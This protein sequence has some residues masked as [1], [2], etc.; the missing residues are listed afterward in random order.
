MFSDL[1]FNPA[2]G[3]PVAESA[4]ETLTQTGDARGLALAGRLLGLSLFRQGARGSVAALE[5]AVGHAHDADDPGVY[6]LVV[7][8]LGGILCD[9]PTPVADALR[10]FDDLRRTSGDDRIVEAMI[11]RFEAVLLAMAGQF[12]ESRDHLRRSSPILDDVDLVTATRVYR[13]LD[14]RAKELIGDL[15]GAEQDLKRRWNDFRDVGDGSLDGRAIDAVGLLAHLY[16]DQGRW[17]EAADVLSYGRDVQPRGFF[18]KEAVVLLAARARVA[19]HEGRYAEAIAMATQAVELVD[20]TDLLD[21]GA[22]AW[23][24]LGEVQRRAGGAA[25]A[26]AAVSRAV[27][28]YEAKGNV[29][30]A[31]SV[32]NTRG[33]ARP[34]ATRWHA[35][36]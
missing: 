15:E 26:D 32:G 19:A 4:I 17:P 29:A 9:G 30:A 13:R 28:L 33:A 1:Q 11:T 34:E 20:A 6:R 21:L 14:A 23:L 31:R 22:C 7:G 12:E 16:C 27:A 35:T 2:D 5:R 8:T 3:Q 36:A 10:R 18:Q 25:A 24:A